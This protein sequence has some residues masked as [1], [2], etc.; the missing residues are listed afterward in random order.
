MR[1]T[2]AAAP[3][4][5][6][7]ADV[8]PGTMVDVC[9]SACQSEEVAYETAGAGQFTTRA[10]RVLGESGRMTHNAFFD[11]V[12]A[13]FGTGAVQHPVLDCAPASRTTMLLEPCAMPVT[14]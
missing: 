13:L 5:M 6:R 10:V 11:R 3:P 8:A 1:G 7:G 4:A 14:S 12:T 2:E 9:F